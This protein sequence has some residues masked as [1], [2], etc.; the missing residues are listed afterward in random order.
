MHLATILENPVEELVRLALLAFI[1]PVFNVPGRKMP[2]AKLAKRLLS[3]YPKASSSLFE[4]ERSLVAWMLI[5]AGSI[6]GTQEAWVQEVWSKVASDLERIAVKD[7][8]SQVMW[9]DVV[10]D[11][12]GHIVFKQLGGP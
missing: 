2:Y 10:H 11:S 4:Q 8:S 5:M 3:I 1:T 6:V 9:I 12:V 7:V